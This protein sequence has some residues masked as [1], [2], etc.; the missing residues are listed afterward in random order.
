[1]ASI[2]SDYKKE[3][4]VQPMF[5]FVFGGGDF[6][7]YFSDLKVLGDFQ[8]VKFNYCILFLNSETFHSG[9]TLFLLCTLF[10]DASFL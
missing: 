6:T 5:G 1:M 10:S 8:N 2:Y 4:F 9:L 7:L 3:F